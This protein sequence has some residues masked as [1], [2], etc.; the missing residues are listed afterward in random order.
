MGREGRATKTYD[1]AGLDAVEN[2]LTVLGDFG[3]EGIGK[4]HAL[5]PLV[6]F[7]GYL[8]MGHIV[9]GQVLAGA[10]GLHGAGCG[11]MHEGG[12]ESRR[13]GNHL[14]GEY[15]VADCDYRFGGGS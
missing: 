13:F 6:T 12:D 4:I 2:E 9:T 8:D 11:R 7:D 14:P 5:D 15:L 3:H 10:D 1:T